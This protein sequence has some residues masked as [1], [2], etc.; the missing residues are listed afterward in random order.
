M[1]FEIITIKVMFGMVIIFKIIFILK[2]IKKTFFYILNFIFNIR[3]SNI[4]KN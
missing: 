4:K 1:C 2:Y 3:I